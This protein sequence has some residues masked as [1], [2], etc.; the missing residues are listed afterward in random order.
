MFSIASWNIRGLNRFP[1]Q[2]EVQ[3]VVISNNL[4]ICSILE[5]HVAN[6]K[7]QSICNKVF[8]NWCW[9][10][11]SNYCESGAR[12][13]IG[14]DPGKV[15]MMP[16]SQ[17]DQ[18]VHRQVKILSD[19]KDIFYSFVYASNKV[20]QRRIL[21]HNLQIHKRF[22]ACNPWVLLGDFNVSLNLED[23]SVG[24]SGITMA[25]KEFREC[26]EAIKVE[27][28]NRT[29]IPYTWNQRPNSETGILKKLDRIM[30]NEGF[31]DKFNNANAE[32]PTGYR[33]IH[34]LS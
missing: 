32:F 9:M 27:D 18:V 14:W 21:W 22:I 28:I 20:E 2:I 25:M 23:S 6:S 11:N 30:G 26:I 29:G 31:L 1:K 24:N 8:G 10:S 5:S 4:S 33:I 19:N 34:L 3:D 7:I 17:T 16:I 13:I 15:Q 12:L